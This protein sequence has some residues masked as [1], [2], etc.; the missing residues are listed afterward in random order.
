MWDQRLR[1]E[2]ASV[3]VGTV[4]SD[5]TGGESSP[6]AAP[7]L[8]KQWMLACRSEATSITPHT[9]GFCAYVLSNRN[10]SSSL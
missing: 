1:H 9:C 5:P 10:M 8:H 6:R 3:Q 4:T 7:L 2:V